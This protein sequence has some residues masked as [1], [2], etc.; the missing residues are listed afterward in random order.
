MR[1]F[2]I[3]GNHPRLSLAE[4]KAVSTEHATPPLLIGPAALVDH[5]DWSGERLMQQLGGTIKLGDIKKDVPLS[6]LNE[7]LL[8]EIIQAEPRDERIVFGLTI[9]GGTTA[10]Q[11]NLSKLALATKRTLITA[12]R[13]VRWVTGEQNGAPTPAAV[14]KL[15]LTTG[16]YDLVILIHEQQAYIGLTTHVQ[17][18]GAWSMRDYGRPGRD[19]ENGML[20]PK[21]ALMMVNLA[22]IPNGGSLLD[23]FC[24]SGTVLMETALATSAAHIIGSDN[25]QTQIDM[26]AQNLRWLI[27]QRILQEKDQK[28]FELA[29]AD[30]RSIDLPFKNQLDAIVT[31]GYLGPP[32]TGHETLPTLQKNAE[33]IEKLWRDALIHLH[34]YLKPTG[35][36]IAVWPAFKS[37]H[38]SERVDVTQD[39][40]KCGY[41]IVNPLEGWDD[42]N[43]PILY[44]RAGQRVMRRIVVLAKI[45][46]NL[47]T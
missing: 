41:K 26:T 4:F 44:H 38:G 27:S 19:D 43:A 2:L 39:L 28:R 10:F 32:L 13:S 9:I 33:E 14:A 34:P 35:K 42:T 8:A 16:G 3:F 7:N 29:T 11:K 46:N 23:P 6:S 22:N 40:E 20:P 21:L 30:A 17:D 47:S 15:G 18:A 24:G 45:A 5:E 36:V 37:S 12:G 25:S 31:E 1:H